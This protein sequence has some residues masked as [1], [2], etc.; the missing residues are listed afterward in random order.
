MKAIRVAEVGGPEVLLLKEVPDLHP[1]PGQVVVNIHAA[2]VNPV[3]TYIRAG[4]YARKATLPYTPGTDGAGAIEA[5]GEGATRFK[6]DDRVYLAGSLTG[7]YAEQALCDEWAVF[8]LPAH[9]SFAQGAG[10]HVPY[11]TAYRAL[12]QIT[13]VRAGDTVLV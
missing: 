8:P 10:I 1:G 11:A 6:L 7:A 5:V 2:G 3:D 13:R 4:T 9:V 12:F